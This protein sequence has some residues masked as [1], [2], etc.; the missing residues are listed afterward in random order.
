M[1]SLDDGT[2]T[3]KRGIVNMQQSILTISIL[4][5]LKNNSPPPSMLLFLKALPSMLAL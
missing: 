3:Q 4:Y 2:S 5:S 1:H